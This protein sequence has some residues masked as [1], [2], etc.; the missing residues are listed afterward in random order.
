ML[1]DHVQGGDR[2]AVISR[3]GRRRTG[4]LSDE[5]YVMA[6]VWL[7]INGAGRDLEIVASVVFDKSVCSLRAAQAT[8]DAGRV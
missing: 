8:L 4:F 7:E 6:Q 1:R 5:G 3:A 2:K